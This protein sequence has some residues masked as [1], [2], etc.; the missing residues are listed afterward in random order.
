MFIDALLK[1]AIAQAFGAA[2][3]SASS[4]DDG[5]GV[6]TRLIGTGETMGFGVEITTLGTV[7]ATTLEAISADDA[8]LTVNV[9][10]HSL[11]TTPVPAPLGG[12]FFVPIPMGAL[13]RR[14]LGLRATTAGGTVSLSAHL[15]PESMFS[16]QPQTLYPK[17]Y[18]V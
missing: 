13:T 14:F 18:V 10:Q 3:V 1:V 6:P 16:V 2:G 17:N 12:M 4:I 9:T 5:V 8:A 15:T 7:A 11:V